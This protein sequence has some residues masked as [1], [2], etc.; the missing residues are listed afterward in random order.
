M[1]GSDTWR[2]T[3]SPRLREAV[4]ARAFPA[5]PSPDA[6]AVARSVL[7]AGGEDVRAVLFFG[8]RKSGATPR[9]SSA[10]DLLLLT[11]DYRPVYAALGRAGVLRGRERV[12]AALNRVLPPNQV[13]VPARLADGSPVLAKC[14]IVGL[15]RL[16]RET[17]AARSD[18]F[19]AGRLFQPVEV[20]H[21]A[22]AA[23]GERLLDA[24]ASAVAETYGWVRP[25]L[26]ERFDAAAYARTALRVS[27]AGE[28]RPEPGARADALLE[29][30]REHHEAV[31]G[32]LLA[33]LAEAGE[34]RPAEGGPWALAR[35]A[36]AGERWRSRL[37]FRRSLLRATARWAKHVA[38]FEGW[39]DFILG[40]VE[41]HN[42]RR[43]VLTERERRL[44][45]VFL[46]PRLVRF[47]REKR[48]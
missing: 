18:H 10:Y 32:T 17:S 27:F 29:A 43:F 40:K 39:L 4:R 14:A 23:T 2:A 9:P 20:L 44:P 7:A 15:E 33:D 35:P 31:L 38:T 48:R 34:L 47:L 28:I 22:D 12:A 26:P 37:Y 13:A 30:Q 11:G 36:G 21:V 42:G 16:L 8:S 25:W 41:R 5:E 46:W 24:L 1:T 45:L 6:A 3:A 19:L